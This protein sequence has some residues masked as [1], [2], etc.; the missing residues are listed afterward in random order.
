M[1]INETKDNDGSSNEPKAN[2]DTRDAMTKATATANKQNAK[3]RTGTHSTAETPD[4]DI[5]IIRARHDLIFPEG[6]AGHRT[7]VSHK[8]RRATPLLTRPDLKT[9]HTSH[10]PPH[11]INRDIKHESSP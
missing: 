4:P 10:Q 2:H 9:T 5:A 1:S 3:R 11:A 7:A 8:R 6:K